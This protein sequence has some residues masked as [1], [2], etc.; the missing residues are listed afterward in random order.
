MRLGLES[1]L[2]LRQEVWL[3]QEDV[4]LLHEGEEI[5][6]MDWGNAFVEVCPKSGLR[7]HSPP[8]QAGRVGSLVQIVALHHVDSQSLVQQPLAD[9]SLYMLLGLL[10]ALHNG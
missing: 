8:M 2:V 3:D 5:T 4:Q 7:S 1:W 6:L 10:Q 9:T